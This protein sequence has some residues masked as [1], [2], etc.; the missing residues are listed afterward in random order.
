ML[1]GSKWSPASGPPSPPRAD[2]R[3]HDGGSDGD[4]DSSPSYAPGG[5]GGRMRFYAARQPRPAAPE[6]EVLANRVCQAYREAP[7]ACNLAQSR[8]SASRPIRGVQ[9]SV[10]TP[11]SSQLSQYTLQMRTAPYTALSCCPSEGAVYREWS[12][13]LWCPGRWRR[14]GCSCPRCGGPA[15]PPPPPPRRAGSR[16]RSSRPSPRSLVAQAGAGCEQLPLVVRFLHSALYG[17][18]TP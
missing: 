1:G 10:Q 6:A 18:R 14:S 3:N 17:M 7:A 13:I 12:M 8:T 15:H 16:R 5:G 2:P 4:G 9:R 11:N